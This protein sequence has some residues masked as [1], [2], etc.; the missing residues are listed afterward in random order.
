MFFS[1]AIRTYSNTFIFEYLMW[2]Y[3][4]FDPHIC[5]RLLNSS[6]FLDIFSNN[7]AF[8]SD[9]FTLII[10]LTAEHFVLLSSDMNFIIVCQTLTF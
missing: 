9:S 6:T 5:S 7:N 4:T 8:Y 10:S 1:I 2:Y 3:N